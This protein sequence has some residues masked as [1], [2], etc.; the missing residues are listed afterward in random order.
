MG[1][2][3]NKRNPFWP[4][5]PPNVKLNQLSPAKLGRDEKAKRYN[6]WAFHF[7]S[8]PSR[9]KWIRCLR[10]VVK[11]GRAEL[12]IEEVSASRIDVIWPHYVTWQSAWRL[13]Q[14]AADK[15]TTFR[16]LG[17]PKGIAGDT[18][19][20][21]S[22]DAA[23]AKGQPMKPEPSKKR[24]KTEK[25]SEA[26]SAT[27]ATTLPVAPSRTASVAAT[28]SIAEP[29]A[30]T[31][32]SW[33]AERPVVASSSSA[34][35][36]AGAGMQATADIG[37]CL[38]P[39]LLPLKLEEMV[40]L[41]K[42]GRR[43]E[44]PGSYD[45]NWDETLGK[46]SFG[47]VHPAWVRGVR[48]TERWVAV[49]VMGSTSSCVD[50]AAMELRRCVAVAGHPDIVKV[51]DVAHFR[52]EPSKLTGLD[53]PRIALVFEY[54]E[55][56]VRHFLNKSRLEIAAVR[57]ILRKVVSALTYMHDL[58]ILH[59]DLKPANIFMRPET[60]AATAWTKWVVASSSKTNSA[61]FQG[62]I[63]PKG[64]IFKVVLGD[65]GN[66]ELANPAERIDHQPLMD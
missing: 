58:G 13:K 19:A 42:G 37:K 6:R 17:E 35:G 65:L 16:I 27:A 59:A 57:H 30:P 41:L 18:E 55:T 33:D 7:P 47:V 36:T 51:V 9:P 38:P 44:G 63:S 53:E 43:V 3:K 20:A 5:L 10:E 21:A 66:A 46:G 48:G 52:K 54:F 2:L 26:P 64:C 1:S 61:V 39:C 11:A 12:Q 49:K 29:T 60:F 24:R 56:S 25:R 14:L 28:A 50:G 40:D 23:C 62:C 45:V 8:G 32:S 34:S 22:A 4:K 15:D 31:A